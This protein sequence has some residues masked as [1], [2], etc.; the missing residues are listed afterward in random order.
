MM[1]VAPA[2]LR[3]AKLFDLQDVESMFCSTICELSAHRGGLLS[4]EDISIALGKM[5]EG[6]LEYVA[7]TAIYKSDGR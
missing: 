2:R 6:S 7:K 5:L 4:V 1:S 3:V